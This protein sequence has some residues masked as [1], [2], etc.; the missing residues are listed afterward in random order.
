MDKKIR[1][2]KKIF[3]F[4]FFCLV[5]HGFVFSQTQEELDLEMEEEI[6]EIRIKVDPKEEKIFKVVKDLPRF[7]G[8]EGQGKSKKELKECSETEML[9]FIYS[10]IKYPKKAREEGTEGKVIVQFIVDH[11]GTVRNI[12]IL[13]DIGNGC[14]EEVKRVILLMN[15]MGQKWI[16]GRSRGPIV[17]A[18][19]TIPITFKLQ[20]SVQK[21]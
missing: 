18:Y 21:K 1:I 17:K 12:K 5:F 3:V 14:G 13:K 15:N 11:T 19:F 9:K 10:N 7:P 4:T 2:M 8:C 16:P 6:N 20:S